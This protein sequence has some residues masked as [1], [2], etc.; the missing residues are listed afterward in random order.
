MGSAP[1][2]IKAIVV[3]EDKLEVKLKKHIAFNTHFM[4]S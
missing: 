4:Q 1:A 2:R 3:G